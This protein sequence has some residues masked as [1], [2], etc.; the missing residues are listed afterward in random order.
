MFH[1]SIFINI[2]SIKKTKAVNKEESCPIT[3]MKNL[4]TANQVR[5]KQD[6]NNLR[7]HMAN[8]SV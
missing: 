5:D 2:I 3:K 8:I 7:N 4:E 1:Q 6:L